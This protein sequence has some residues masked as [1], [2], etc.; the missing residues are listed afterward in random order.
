[1]RVSSAGTVGAI[2]AI[3]LIV[4]RDLGPSFAIHSRGA[5]L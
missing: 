4:A 1:V 2:L 5:S 3:R